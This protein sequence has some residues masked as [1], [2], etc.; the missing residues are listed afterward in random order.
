MTVWHAV[1]IRNLLP[2]RTSERH[3]EVAALEAELRRSS[4]SE[5]RTLKTETPPAATLAQWNLVK[6]LVDRRAFSWTGLF[7]RLEQVIPKDVRLTSISPSVRKG[8][9][10][11][12]VDAA[13]RSREAGW[14]FVRVLEDG[15]DFDDVY[16]RSESGNEFRY[17]IRYRPQ[18][19]PAADRG[20]RPPP[21]RSRPSRRRR[22]RRLARARGTPVKPF[23]RR[24]LLV[25]AL[26]LLALN[27][28]TYFAYTLP[29]SVRE[30]DIAAR[31]VV[32]REEVA[33]ERARVDG[34]RQR[35][36]TIEANTADVARFYKALGRKDSLLEIQEDIVGVG[37]P[38]R[39]H[40][41]QPLLRQRG[42]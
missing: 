22:R 12:D 25:P 37:P 40:P 36:R 31:A 33:E 13:V 24:R 6:D 21:P 42:R 27:A 38:A 30:R 34:V 29:R 23:W 19:A 41:R 35:A 3:R 10:E 5:A 7:A 4:A 8:Q 26:V 17:G 14:E 18:K 20:R 11:L 16:P 1:V 2:A 9:V 39:P 28:G 15:G 32:L